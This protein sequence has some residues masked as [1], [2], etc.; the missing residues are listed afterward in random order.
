MVASIINEP[1]QKRQVT[2][3]CG[4]QYVERKTASTNVS[5]D[6]V[7]LF[8]VGP[9][10]AEREQNLLDSLLSLHAI[11]HANFHKTCPRQNESP[12]ANIRT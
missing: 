2:A 11:A 9:K 4:Q 8:S 12:S 3:V 5:S 6:I 10:Q 7:G 1:F